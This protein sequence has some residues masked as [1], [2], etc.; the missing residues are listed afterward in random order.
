[1]YLFED[2]LSDLDPFLKLIYTFLDFCLQIIS[3]NL[4]IILSFI[5]LATVVRV[6]FRIYKWD[7]DIKVEEEEPYQPTLDY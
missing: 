5:I 6:L 3:S 2:L 4:W 7:Y 1:M